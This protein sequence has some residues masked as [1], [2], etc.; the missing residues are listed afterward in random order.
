MQWSFVTNAIKADSVANSKAVSLAASFPVGWRLPWEQWWVLWGEPIYM[1]GGISI[2]SLLLGFWLLCGPALVEFFISWTFTVYSFCDYC[3]Y[4]L[5]WPWL[6]SGSPSMLSLQSP[7]SSGQS[8]DWN[9]QSSSF[10]QTMCVSRGDRLGSLIHLMCAAPL[11]LAL[12]AFLY[13]VRA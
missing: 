13:H 12:R 6:V 1:S 10:P 7:C 3:C 11:T 4:L 5:L 2:I 9:H 8:L